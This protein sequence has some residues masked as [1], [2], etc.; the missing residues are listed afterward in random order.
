MAAGRMAKK[1]SEPDAKLEKSALT[2]NPFARL[3]AIEVPLVTP[4][5]TTPQPAGGAVIPE[6]TREAS[7]AGKPRG[8]LLLRR[9]TKHRGG[10]AV[11]V[12]SGLS[13]SGLDATAVRELAQ[14]LK[15]ALGC[16]GTV[17]DSKGQPEIILQGDRPAQVAELLRGYG[18]RVEGVTR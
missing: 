15:Q 5:D 9:E 14:R 10:K 3:G 12:V 17:E 4:E 2:H 7:K 13:S 1:K 16:G 11:V 6:I 8:R 18:Y